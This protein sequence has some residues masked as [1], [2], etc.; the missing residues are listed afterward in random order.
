MIVDDLK[1]NPLSPSPYFGSSSVPL[2]SLSLEE[3]VVNLSQPFNLR[4]KSFLKMKNYNGTTGSW[5]AFIE[6]WEFLSEI[7]V[8]KSGCWSYSLISTSHLSIIMT[9]NLFSSVSSLSTRMGTALSGTEE[10]SSATQIV[11]QGQKPPLAP[12]KKSVTIRAATPSRRNSIKLVRGKGYSV[13]KGGRTPLLRRT[14]PITVQAANTPSDSDFVVSI[15]PSVK[16]IG[17]VSESGL[18]LSTSQNPEHLRREL[19]PYFIRNET[20]TEIIYWFHDKPFKL[21]NGAEAMIEVGR[22][23]LRKKKTLAATATLAHGAVWEPDNSTFNCRR[24]GKEF[25]FFVRRHH[26]RACGK[27]FCSSCSSK[28]AIVDG[29]RSR[30]CVDCFKS[31]KTRRKSN[32]EPQAVRFSDPKEIEKS[33]IN[34][35]NDKI[36]KI[37]NSA[38]SSSSV[39]ASIVADSVKSPE[40]ERNESMLYS[41]FSERDPSSSETPQREYPASDS[42]SSDDYSSEE[43]TGSTD[44]SDSILSTPVISHPTN[45]PQ[46][47][48]S[49]ST[50]PILPSR[51]L[52]EKSSTSIETSSASPSS[53]SLASST[54][55]QSTIDKISESRPI[56]IHRRE[57]SF[58]ITGGNFRPV[59]HIRFNKAGTRLLQVESFESKS[60]VVCEVHYLGGS[61]CLSLR[62]NIIIENLANVPMDFIFRKAESN[63]RHEMFNVAPGQSFP[64]PVLLTSHDLH[65]RPHGQ[66]C[67]FSQNYFDLGGLEALKDNSLHQKTHHVGCWGPTREDTYLFSCTISNEGGEDKFGRRLTKQEFKITIRTPLEICNLLATSMT[68][69]LQFEKKE[70]V[71]DNLEKGDSVEVYR[72]LADTTVV[73]LKLRIADFHW[74]DYVSFDLSQDSNEVVVLSSIKKKASLHLNVEINASRESGK[75]RVV[76]FAPFWLVNR[77]LLPIKYRLRNGLSTKDDDSLILNEFCEGENMINYTTSTEPFMFSSPRLIN[78]VITRLDLKVGESVWSKGINV[79]KTDVVNYI[80]LPD[81]VTEIKPSSMASSIRSSIHG[82]LRSTSS[83]SSSASSSSEKL[84]EEPKRRLFSIGISSSPGPSKFW[85]TSVITFTPRYLL[86]N[87]SGREIFLKQHNVEIKRTLMVGE[88]APWHWMDADQPPIA[89]LSHNERDW[90]KP[91]EFDTVQNFSVMVRGMEHIFIAG[92]KVKLI[93]AIIHVFFYGEQPYPPYRIENLTYDKVIHFT[94]EKVSSNDSLK[95]GFSLPYTWEEPLLPHSLKFQVFPPGKI[96]ILQTLDTVAQTLHIPYNGLPFLDIDIVVDG[97]TKFVRFRDSNLHRKITTE[98]SP[99]LR[100]KKNGKNL[101]KYKVKLSSIEISLVDHIPRE[102]INITLEEINIKTII[103]TT[104]KLVLS[105]DVKNI[106]IDNQLYNTV[107]PVVLCKHDITSKKNFLRFKLLQTTQSG[108]NCEIFAFAGI[109]LDNFNLNIS[110]DLLM[111]LFSF[112]DHEIELSGDS[113]KENDATQLDVPEVTESDYHMLYFEKISISPVSCN[114]SLQSASSES[115]LKVTSSTLAAI[116]KYP[117]FSCNFEDAQIK[118]ERFELE[119]PF[120]TKADL[121]EKISAFYTHNILSQILRLLGSFDVIGS[122]AGLVECYLE[123]QILQLGSLAPFHLELPGYLLTF[124]HGL[125]LGLKS[126]GKGLADG[127][128]GIVEQPIKA[129]MAKKGVIRGIGK[130]LIGV[131]VKPVVGVNNSR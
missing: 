78:A 56:S 107:Y 47:I 14:A 26:C 126:F 62:S 84:L 30:V 97:P 19:H 23:S 114:L 128:F 91:F 6:P 122:P 71:M 104:L 10:K 81:E 22:K 2:L 89:V 43:E 54:L 57:V 125:A 60:V 127:L 95:P 121:S 37:E 90:S 113:E 106:Q 131:A 29:E 34:G 8:D 50:L 100:A 82:F 129:G 28:H 18:S 120:I 63:E 58:L 1:E 119:H 49:T 75:C 20:G 101:A 55:R 86:H 74:S 36:E 88:E 77:T 116:L 103:S 53:S 109:E 32:K 25:K 40:L 108:N 76:V 15:S 17:E 96:W 33:E 130:G 115:K 117:I 111:A 105:V 93:G 5:E 38:L 45:L 94:Q 35:K 51:G 16:S 65:M 99:F 67:N 68:W 9:K 21:E 118:L 69:K 59:H 110:E 24:C 41:E 80:Y 79:E 123:W 12:M 112:I 87:K 27:I 39:I 92:I 85:R 3:M 4:S 61:K 52:S 31:I 64:V 70:L 46:L 11:K 83:S 124:G 44:R 98:E 7:S 42:S 73:S 72:G 66:N 102:L 48:S 13:S